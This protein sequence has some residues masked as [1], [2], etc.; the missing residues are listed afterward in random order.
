MKDKTGRVKA[1]IRIRNLATP[2]RTILTEHSLRLSLDESVEGVRELDLR[3][4]QL[5]A[6]ELRVLAPFCPLVEW[7]AISESFF[8][9][10]EEEEEGKGERERGYEVLD[11][12]WLR[13]RRLRPERRELLLLSHQLFPKL[14]SILLS[15]VQ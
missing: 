13:V 8:F 5:G 3:G 6:G 7:L 10:T 4:C 14:Q 1:E 9:Q 2:R 11:R 15:S 12:C